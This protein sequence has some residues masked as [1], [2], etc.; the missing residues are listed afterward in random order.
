MIEMTIETGA[1]VTPQN[2]KELTWVANYED[3]TKLEQFQDGKEMKYADI[4][5]D[6]LVRFDMIDVATKKPIYA[7]YLSEGQQ[8]IFRRRTLKQFKMPDVVLFL[9]GYKITFMTNI[10]AKTHVVINYLH[11]DGSVALD[12]AR[13]NLEL[14]PFE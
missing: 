12:G 13:N 11:P 8:L 2:V 6:R 1:V 4:D 14:L 5:R 9:V 10:G 3:G 7:L